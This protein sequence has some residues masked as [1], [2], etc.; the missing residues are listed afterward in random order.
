MKNKEN[1]VYEVKSILSVPQSLPCGRCHQIR[2][3]SATALDKAIL[4]GLDE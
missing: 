4:S 3:I 1:M 2:E